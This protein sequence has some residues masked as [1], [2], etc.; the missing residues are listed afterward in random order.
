MLHAGTGGHV[1][2]FTSADHAAIAHGVFVLD[3]AAD[4]IADDFHV[5]VRVRPETHARHHEVIVDDAQAA[6]THPARIMIL[7]EAERVITIQPTVIG[8]ASFIGTAN[9]FHVTTMRA[10]PVLR[11]YHV[12]CLTI[13]NSYAQK[14]NVRASIQN[15]KCV[16]KSAGA[17][18]QITQQPF[19]G[20]PGHYRRLCDLG[21]AAPSGAD[22]VDYALDMKYMELQ[23]ELLRYL[24]PVL[25]TAWGKNLFE[26]SEVGYCGFAEEFWAALLTGGAL[27]KVFTEAERDAFI[28]YMRD[29][30]LDR[31]DAEKSL[32]F[33]GMD[34]SP[35]R[36]VDALV[37]YGTLSSDLEALW[38]EWWEMKTQGHAIASFQYASA[39]M[40]EDQKN[41]VFDAWTKDKG[42]GPPALHAS[43]AM[44]FSV[45]WKQENIVFLKK[46]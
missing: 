13:T 15:L 1:L 11:K 12:S 46:L 35:Y 29:S 10:V 28:A 2:E 17:P 44:V 42:G 8:V 25:L 38:T 24:T 23:P 20:D 30:V 9:R 39:L 19:D 27:T 7:R 14:T 22:L 26:G 36:W 18:K 4:D 40:Y 3:G 16:I 32:R 43:G 21:G 41:P 33:S 5:A 45:S 37:S 34:A 31:L 6:V